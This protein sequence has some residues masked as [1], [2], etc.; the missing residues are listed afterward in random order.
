MILGASISTNSLDN[1]NKIIDNLAQEGCHDGYKHVKREEE[2]E[3]FRYFQED[4]PNMALAPRISHAQCVTPARKAIYLDDDEIEAIVDG[5]IQGEYGLHS[6]FRGYMRVHLN[7]LAQK[8]K[9]NVKGFHTPEAGWTVQ[10]IIPAILYVEDYCSSYRIYRFVDK[11]YM[12]NLAE[13]INP[14]L[15]IVL[16]NSNIYTL[17]GRWVELSSRIKWEEYSYGIK[18]TLNEWT[19]LCLENGYDRALLDSEGCWGLDPESLRKFTEV[20]PSTRRKAMQVVLYAAEEDGKFFQAGQTR[21]DNLYD[22]YPFKGET[23]GRYMKRQRGIAR[24][25][26]PCTSGCLRILG[27]MSRQAV[28]VLLDASV[29]SG[30]Y[31]KIRT[32][33]LNWAAL[34]EWQKLS[35]IEQTSLMGARESW[36]H[37]MKR[38][39]KFI[40]LMDKKHRFH[41]QKVGNPKNF[42]KMMMLW[43]KNNPAAMAQPIMELSKLFSSPN[44]VKRLL[45]DPTSEREVH[46]LGQFQYTG[47]WPSWKGFFMKNK[48]TLHRANHCTT[49]EAQNERLPKSAQELNLF[50]QKQRYVGA[51]NMQLVEVA[52]KCGISEDSYMEYE[53]LYERTKT[54]ESCP[55]VEVSNGDYCLYKLSHDDP[56]GAML[57]LMTDCCQHLDGAGSSCAEH[58]VTRSTS[59][60][61]VVERKGEIVAQSWAWRGK[62]GE[63]VFDSIEGLSGYNNEVIRSLFVEAAD[64]MLG[65]LGISAVHVGDTSYG[66]TRNLFGNAP[67]AVAAEMV[68]HCSYSDAKHQK[69]ICKGESLGKFKGKRNLPAKSTDD[70]AHQ[71]FNRLVEGSDVFCEYC[72]AEVHPDC[73]ICPECGRD[74]SEWVS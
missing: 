74:I 25:T 38:A 44:E 24:A 67:D 70:R 71:D 36:R 13:D 32:K 69:L 41:I 50:A 59:A 31:E 57:G 72:D 37:V 58:G 39:P 35:K 49:W 66:L 29:P 40:D 16:R 26:K 62:K 20:S 54:A 15:R 9:L 21:F 28:R 34:R 17:S 4:E 52:A 46:D 18:S 43:G 30:G 27:K 2:P 51:S 8:Y 11:D 47:T 1:L 22:E 7:Y 45:D 55:F 3:V 60:F 5:G 53:R 65:K 64:L 10:S 12:P 23:F 73:N 6:E 33:D 61:Y 14:L 68:E 56:R 48:G 19:T 42:I 63:L